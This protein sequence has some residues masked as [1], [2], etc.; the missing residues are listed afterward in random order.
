ML[1]V[2]KKIF[3]DLYCLDVFKDYL[4]GTLSSRIVLHKINIV[5]SPMEDTNGEDGNNLLHMSMIATCVWQIWGPELGWRRWWS[6]PGGEVMFMRIRRLGKAL[7]ED[8]GERSKG[9][10]KRQSPSILWFSSLLC[11]GGPE[12]V[13]KAE[14]ETFC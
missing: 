9:E 3:I 12:L 6:F 2:E 5:S 11:R 4:L 1:K 10:R 14:A 7:L 8:D 13:R